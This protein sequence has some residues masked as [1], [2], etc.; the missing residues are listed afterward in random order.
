[1]IQKPQI[2]G[3]YFQ[4]TQCFLGNPSI[5]EYLYKDA[6]ISADR[7]CCKAIS[8]LLA[9]WKIS[10]LIQQKNVENRGKC[11]FIKTVE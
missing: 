1:M 7:P 8:Y 2:R 6:G 10:S 4:R 11:I 9:F 3:T 5:Q